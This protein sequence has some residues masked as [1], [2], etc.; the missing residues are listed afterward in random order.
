MSLDSS[1]CWTIPSERRFTHLL[2][3]Y[4]LPFY[5]FRSINAYVHKNTQGLHHCVC[6]CGTSLGQS[7]QQIYHICRD[8]PPKPL[9]FNHK[10]RPTVGGAPFSD[11]NSCWSHA[12][13]QWATIIADL[14]G[15][16]RELLLGDGWCDRTMWKTHR[17]GNKC[18]CRT[19]R[20]KFDY[21]FLPPTGKL[22]QQFFFSKLHSMTSR[23]KP[24]QTP[25]A[26][27]NL[28]TCVY[29][30][31]MYSCGFCRAHLKLLR[32]RLT[33]EVLLQA[34]TSSAEGSLLLPTL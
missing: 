12:R 30:L 9:V 32:V 4:S 1:K 2:L 14:H 20:S 23:Q 13:T 25:E 7:E 24:H 3:A 22:F 10:V 18:D 34:S 11:E 26:T 8:D 5:P 27:L 6:V 31:W 21:F 16:I 19:A 33:E 15:S 29:C 17:S 28:I